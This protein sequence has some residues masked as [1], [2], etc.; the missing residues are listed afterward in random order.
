MKV[1]SWKNGNHRRAM[2]QMNEVTGAVYIFHNNF[3]F[4]FL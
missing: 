1:Y 4:I 3:I 2:E